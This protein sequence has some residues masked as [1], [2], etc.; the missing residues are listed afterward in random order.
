MKSFA[1]ASFLFLLPQSSQVPAAQ[2]QSPQRFHRRCCDSHWRPPIRFREPGLPWSEYRHPLPRC[3]LIRHRPERR[4]LCLPARF[5]LT[6]SGAAGYAGGY[7]GSDYGQPG[8]VRF[9]GS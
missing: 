1:V 3:P 6:R 5:R 2:Q 8:Q 4:P 7:S 9:Q